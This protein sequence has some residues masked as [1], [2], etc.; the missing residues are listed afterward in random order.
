[1]ISSALYKLR[2]FNELEM[3]TY[4]VLVGG[5]TPGIAKFERMTSPRLYWAKT[6]TKPTVLHQSRH[7]T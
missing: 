5:R 7:L 2:S 6:S 3:S 4:M 1:M